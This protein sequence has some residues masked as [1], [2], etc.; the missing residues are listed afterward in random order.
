[1]AIDWLNATEAQQFGKA[2]AK[3]Y[4]SKLPPDAG[5]ADKKL[6]NKQDFVA[7]KML[8]QVIAF[9][10]EQKLNLYKK[11]QLG[12]AFKWTLKE[13]GYADEEVNRLTGTLMRQL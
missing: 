1:M 9:K 4:I 2:L 11:A 12:N 13:S 5:K 3:F 7:K 8:E 6:A 10:Q